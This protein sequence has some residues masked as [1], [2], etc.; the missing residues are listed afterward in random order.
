MPVEFMIGLLIAFVVV[1]FLGH[2]SWLILAAIF[3]AIFS[4]ESPSSNRAN[5]SGNPNSPRQQLI[6]DLLAY[7]R[8]VKYLR[9]KGWILPAEQ[10]RL[11]SLARR[12]KEDFSAAH[13]ASPANTEVSRPPASQP[14]TPTSQPPTPATHRLPSAPAAPRPTPEFTSQATSRP[15]AP[16][17]PNPTPP[18]SSPLTSAPSPAPAEPASVTPVPV[19]PAPVTPTPVTPTPVTP[20]PTP[21]APSPLVQ[22]PSGSQP[23]MV[24][25]QPAMAVAAQQVQRPSL[26]PRRALSEVLQSFLAAHNI[27][28]GELAA[29]ILIVVCSIGLVISLWSTLTEANRLIPAAVFLG[30]VAA[31]EGAGLYTLKRWRLR[32]TSR[33]VLI[34][35]T[36]LVPLSMMAG[37]SIAGGGEQAIS[38][39][40]P[41]TL[42]AV[43][44]GGA[45]CVGMLYAAGAA[46]VGKPRRWLWTIMLGLPTLLLPFA[47]ATA[48]LSHQ[49]VPWIMLLASVAVALGLMVDSQQ[50]RLHPS[51]KLLLPAKRNHLTMLYGLVVYALGVLLAMFV[52]RGERDLATLL[53]LALA[54]IPA[55]AALTATC[56]EVAQRVTA[57]T[58]RVGYQAVGIMSL[59]A[60]VAI[61]PPSLDRF[62][63]VS[64][65]TLGVAT[66]GLLLAFTLRQPRLLALPPLAATFWAPLATSVWYGQQ[67]WDADLAMWRRYVS[68]NAMISMLAVGGLTLLVAAV[69]RR[70]AK[71]TP[72]V[73]WV[74]EAARWLIYAAGISLTLG[75]LVGV[76]VGL[77][78]AAW[79]DGVPRSLIVLALAT[80]ACAA[81]SVSEAIKLGR[82]LAVAGV[83]TAAATAIFSFDVWWQVEFMIWIPQLALAL[84]AAALAVAGLGELAANW[85]LGQP[86]PAETGMPRRRV[87]VSRQRRLLPVWW[88][89]AGL[90]GVL[91][92]LTTPFCF[93]S[94][95]WWAIAIAV[96]GGLFLLTAA[97]RSRRSGWIPLA[98]LASGLSIVLLIAQW[99]PDWLLNRETWKNTSG[100]FYCLAIAAGVAAGWSLLRDFAVGRWRALSRVLDRD[101]VQ[102]DSWLGYL[103]LFVLAA[104]V[105]INLLDVMLCH[106]FGRVASIADWTAVLSG[107]SMMLVLALARSWPLLLGSTSA[108]RWRWR[109]RGGSLVNQVQVWAIVMTGLPVATLAL[110]QVYLFGTGPRGVVAVGWAGA[111]LVTGLLVALW[112][113]S[114]KRDKL[115]GTIHG[116][117]IALVCLAGFLTGGAAISLLQGPVGLVLGASA[118]GHWLLLTC[119]AW[120][121]LGSLELA[122]MARLI[123][124][125]WPAAL[126][127][128]LLPLTLVVAT[129]LF[130]LDP[131]WTSLLAAAVGSL[132]GMQLLASLAQRSGLTSR[133]DALGWPRSVRAAH[134]AS[135]SSGL[136]PPTAIGLGA[137]LGVAV[138]ALVA[139]QGIASVLL[140]ELTRID[141]PAV[142]LALATLGSLLLS[143]Q[144][145]DG[146]VQ[147]SVSLAAGL[148]SISGLLSLTLSALPSSV[149]PWKAVVDERFVMATMWML[150]AALAGTCGLASRSLAGRSVAGVGLSLSVA[151]LVAVLGWWE[152]EADSMRWLLLAG[153]AAAWNGGFGLAIYRRLQLAALG[154]L[155][156]LL[157]LV[158]GIGVV[159]LLSLATEVQWALAGLLMAVLA[160]VW[161][162]L[163]P[164]VAAAVS[165]AQASKL[166]AV[167]R[168]VRAAPIVIDRW[169][170]SG[171]ILVSLRPAFR[172][173]AIFGG[174]PIGTTVFL[175]ILASFACLL[176]VACYRRAA[177]RIPLPAVMAAVQVSS[178]LVCG[179]WLAPN[180]A[181]PVAVV[182]CLL[183]A[184]LMIVGKANWMWLLRGTPMAAELAA[185]KGQGSDFG[186]EFATASTAEVS[187]RGVLQLWQQTDERANGQPA[188][189]AGSVTLA[190]V[191]IT[192]FIWQV[193][194]QGP[195]AELSPLV[196]WG[197]AVLFPPLLR[198]LRLFENLRLGGALFAGLA[199][200]GVMSAAA[201]Y[202]QWVHLSAAWLILSG[203]WLLTMLVGTIW[204]SWQKRGWAM[205]MA[206]VLA[207]SS[208]ILAAAQTGWGEPGWSIWVVSSIAAVTLSL[209]MWS[210]LAWWQTGQAYGV[211]AA[212]CGLFV[213]ADGSPTIAL[214]VAKVAFGF[215]FCAMCWRLLASERWGRKQQFAETSEVRLLWIDNLFAIGSLLAFLPVIGYLTLGLNGNALGLAVPPMAAPAGV[216]PV[217]VMLLGISAMGVVIVSTLVRLRSLLAIAVAYVA[218]QLLSA[219]LVG[220]LVPA[221][222][223]VLPVALQCSA[224]AV[225]SGLWIWAWPLVLTSRAAQQ[226]FGAE[227]DDGFEVKSAIMYQLPGRQVLSGL[228]M[229]TAGL[230]T[231]AASFAVLGGIEATSR[232]LLI[233]SVGAMGLSHGAIAGWYEAFAPRLLGRAE[234]LR[235]LAVV[236]V[237]SAMVLA[238]LGLERDARPWWLLATM[239]LWI[240]AVIITPAALWVAANVLGLDRQRW[241]G[242]LRLAAGLG[243]ALAAFALPLI[244]WQEAMLRGTSQLALVPLPLVIGVAFLIGA[245]AVV[246]AI[247]GLLR[248]AELS[249]LPALSDQQR[250]IAL[251][252]AQALGGLAWLHIYLCKPDL[253]L[254]GLRPY[255]PYIVMGL[256][257]LS[258][259]LAEWGR[260][261]EDKVVGQTMRQTTLFLPLI[262]VI[263]FWLSAGEMDWTFG[264]QRV[265]YAFFLVVAAIFYGGLAVLWRQ[266]RLP[267]V[268]G[269]ILANAALW[270]V[271]V[272]NPGFGFLAHPQL[273]LIPPAVCVLAAAQLERRRLAPQVLVTI[274]Y[275][276]TLVIYVSSTADIMFGEIGSSLLG[277]ML[278]ILLALLGMVA[279]V[280]LRT[281]AFLYLGTMFILVGVLSMVW[282]AGQAIDQNWPW[283]VFGI[284]MG[285]LILGGLMAI[286]KN[287]AQLQQWV[288]RLNAWDA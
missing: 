91:A 205:A 159:S 64:L 50:L 195:Q 225:I 134:L 101:G 42:V 146:K 220:W 264:G 194:V 96:G 74:G 278:L 87:I 36:M 23:P 35:A 51:R 170:A 133:I 172:T 257:F 249:V 145:T 164:A 250:R 235:K 206:G 39:A 287:K 241:R 57:A 231:I 277:P 202:W 33:A 143:Q 182:F 86:L 124:R 212:A 227:S 108:H 275:A 174:E 183:A 20:A 283:W 274:R 245:G 12:A 217:D 176:V 62:L 248:P 175:L 75:G 18:T 271:L 43:G 168:V 19:T 229:A 92:L 78:P 100:L 122:L 221:D 65:W 68:G 17:R 282:H 136:F 80:L 4:H 123:D 32:H 267:R 203:I 28:W 110:A 79:L 148:I 84:T 38:L 52:I 207:V 126:L 128:M 7:G 59:L 166:N 27:R 156:S 125:Q 111:I 83:L 132:L 204:A 1:T 150:G 173:F 276:A 99:Q 22:T 106:A 60:I 21:L 167:Q 189:V 209:L 186:Q 256:A 102:L 215:A 252:L 63:W 118:S 266:D 61:L 213:L 15:V 131:A 171:V 29:G 41:L 226:E 191:T 2:F 160:S 190:I 223:Q 70:K 210:R 69:L 265:S 201:V 9:W 288:R 116:C 147:K 155:V 55:L 142:W 280:V 37:I 76:A 30:A 247:V 3:R 258:A 279:G 222:F 8:V 233:A 120:G 31:I 178:L 165:S 107:A 188:M 53:P 141:Q 157:G 46:L 94:Q 269:I 237:V 140:V 240:A 163:T 47:S 67:V 98:Q 54:L 10:E 49:A 114:G 208:S 139:V 254:V 270:V 196:L 200:S 219:T 192:G 88:R 73:G 93:K 109:E 82:L 185:G 243:A 272:Q 90:L 234:V 71:L 40:E 244:F 6:S 81:A 242:G 187:Q 66:T 197:L 95:P 260:R 281:R 251:Y 246:A 230:L 117:F 48:R 135:A 105:G 113:L 5:A 154:Q 24:Q 11:E 72:A 129:R 285:I 181:E 286:E 262:P 199:T 112:Q 34:I 138:A 104:T 144:T 151:A 177:N 232:W 263:G 149:W 44:G 228:V 268:A 180:A 115:R 89:D 198:Q 153:T 25:P 273:W 77:G 179:W 193:L 152:G 121:L 85:Q 137:S 130:F 127:V 239:R 13:V 45:A 16:V 97:V 14:I 214:L 184:A 158:A 216:L 103:S 26:E 169:L 236:L 284:T 253:L 211:L 255:W 259:G 119:L 161:N 162:M 56:W 218:S 238:A 58:Y 224:A 261:R